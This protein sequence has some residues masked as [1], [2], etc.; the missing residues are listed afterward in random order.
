MKKIATLFVVLVFL[1]AACTDTSQNE[2]ET[3]GADTTQTESPP[4]EIEVETVR[5]NAK[6]T[7]QSVE[8]LSSNFVQGNNNL[9]FNIADI[10]Y[11]KEENLALSPV[12]IELALA[13]TRIGASGETASE[14]KDSLG[15]TAMTDEEIISTCKSLMWR[16]NTGGMEAANSI[17]LGDTYNFDKEFLSTCTDDFMAD[18]LP[19]LIPGA[20]DSI[21]AWVSDKTHSKIEEILS[22]EPGPN[23]ELILCNALY[24]LGEW[25]QP[26]EAYKSGDQVYHTPTGDVQTAF[27]RSEWLVPYINNDTFSMISLEFKNEI[28]EGKYA[29]AFMLP[30]EG[31]DIS[32]MLSSLSGDIFVDALNIMES[33]EVWIQL[34]KFEYTFSSPLNESFKALGMERA[35]DAVS[36]DFSAMTQESNELFISKILHK[37]YIRI[38]E[39]GA[40]AAAVTEV[41][42]R[43]G[44][45]INLEEPPKFFADRPFAFAIYSLEDGA[46]AFMGV[47]NDPT[48]E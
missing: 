32:D 28:D 21:N 46:I 10:L 4:D 7:E 12:S 26:F 41:E 18:A 25:K 20:K 9:G 24:Y 15:L 30:N 39:L 36:A 5:Y 19:L 27:M 8:P 29:M 40:E 31:I 13:M 42:L 47:V 44:A 45:A 6:L 14:M 3:V 34:P 16:A 23:T 35:F 1:L 38:D 43:D 33:Q 17:W 11:N 2:S 37:C 22:E 48:K